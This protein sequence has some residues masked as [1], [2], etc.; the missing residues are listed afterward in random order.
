MRI[1]A[2]LR[3]G[4]WKPGKWG[5]TPFNCVGHYTG[6]DLGDHLPGSSLNQE[7]LE[8]TLKFRVGVLFRPDLGRKQRLETV[9]ILQEYIKEMFE[10]EDWEA[11]G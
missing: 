10:Y 4:F 5:D 7:L 3:I 9:L 11:A 8:G 6:P 1:T 2:G